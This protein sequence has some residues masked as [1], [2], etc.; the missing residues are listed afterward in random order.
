MK[1][2][3]EINEQFNKMG[4]D[5][6][7]SKD[8]KS[9]PTQQSKDIETSTERTLTDFEQ[10]QQALGWDPNGVKGAEEWSRHYPLF[11]TIENLNKENK[12]LNKTLDY[13]KNAM[14]RQQAKEQAKEEQILRQQ[15]E[16]AIKVGDVALVNHIENTY[17]QQRQAQAPRQTIKAFDDF[18]EKY[19]H[20]V[21]ATGGEELDIKIYF[22]QV[23]IALGNQLPPEEHVKRVEEALHRKF[24]KYFNKD[25][26][27]DEHLTQSVESGIQSNVKKSLRKKYSERDLTKD[28]KDMFA[29]FKR[30]GFPI[31]LEKY[32]SDLVDSG[33][34][35]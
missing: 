13:V 21:N 27:D 31:T 1:E 11:K 6:E 5:V 3:Q 15:R 2:Q 33:E 35:K 22:K 9:Q 30:Y 34:I 16:N 19:D 23:D 4:V 29:N 25:Q 20:I 26:D 7:T 10:Q 14:E 18:N 17:Q 8:N 12:K 24:P 28:Q 32:I